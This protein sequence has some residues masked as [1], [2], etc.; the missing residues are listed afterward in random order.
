ML[1]HQ[2]MS[3]PI[4]LVARLFFAP[5]W[6]MEIGLTKFREKIDPH[7]DREAWSRACPARKAAYCFFAIPAVLVGVVFMVQFLSILDPCADGINRLLS[8]NGHH[9]TDRSEAF[10][11]C[12]EFVILIWFGLIGYGKHLYESMNQLGGLIHSRLIK[13]RLGV[14]VVFG[15]LVFGLLVQAHTTRHN[16][17]HFFCEFLALSFFAIGNLVMVLGIRQQPK[18]KFVVKLKSYVL[19]A[20]LFVLV[21][22]LVLGVL[23]AWTTVD[24]NLVQ[25]YALLLSFGLFFANAFRAAEHICIKYEESKGT[26]RKTRADETTTSTTTEDPAMS[27]SLDELKPKGETTMTPSAVA[28]PA[29]HHTIIAPADHQPRGP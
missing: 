8:R 4:Q 6:P 14:W 28:P 15:A 5:F 19:M 13:V 11:C 27:T 7:L 1:I 26:T 18:V 17:F 24:E 2:I 22:M 25:P 16:S 29:M 20:D 21:S 9:V 3:R 10:W 12:Y 23:V